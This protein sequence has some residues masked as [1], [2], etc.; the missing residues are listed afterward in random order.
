MSEVQNKTIEDI[1][2]LVKQKKRWADTKIIIKAY[3]YAKEKHGTQCRKSGE[4][5]IIHPVQVAYI[6]ADIG[7]DESTICAA[8]LH[9][10]VEDTEVTHEDLVRDFSEEI[11]NM[12]A[13][14][15][16]LGELRYQASTEE[17]QVE[18]YRKMFLAMG[19][20]IR[21]IIIKL[22]DRLHN[23]RTLKYLRRDRQIANAKETME[24]Y[25][26]LA[27]RLGIY[28]L[29][30][31]LEDLAFK[32]LYPEEY[33][34]LVAGIDKKREERL[35]FIEKI[36]GDIRGSLKKQKIEAEVTGRAKHLY[37]IYRKM[38][39]D[40]KTLDQIYDLFAL[41]ILV[42][43]VKDCYTA[44]GVVH[45]MY[46]PMPGRFK[47]YIAVP[48]PNMYQSIHTTLLG[49]KGTPFEVQIRTWEMHRIAEYGIA[50]HWAYKEA[51][52]GKKGKQVVEVTNDKLSWL[53]ETLE[54]QQDMK[55]PQEF[56]NTLK[57]ELFEDEV[58]VFTPKGKILV[59]PREATPIDFAYS[60]HEEIGNHM[61]GCKINS[62]MMP[63]I[64]KLKSGDI[65][66]IM[67]SD[68]QKGPSRDWLKF[69]KTTKAKSKIQS[70]FKKEQRTENIEK[71]K[72][73]IEKE[74]KRIGI[75]HDELF[76]QDYINAALDRYKFK[77][78]EEMYASVG[79]GAISQVKI[80][81]RML[82][83]YRKAHNEENIEQKIEELTSKR[84]HIKPSNTGVVVKGIDNCLVKLSKCCNPVP[85]DNIIGYITKGRGVSVH[86]TDCVNVKDL[87]KE[88]DRIIDV[89]WYTE[90][91][92]AY[93]VDI[94]VFA[95]DRA[96]L[97]AEVIQVLGNVKTKL[98]ALNSKTT[99]EHIA[100]IEIT[101]EVE[102]IEELNKVLK[103]LRKI[104]S[105][106]EVARKK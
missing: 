79:F 46:S 5:Y 52:Y 10:V 64:T 103:E 88:E 17:R 81:S 2:S 59:L 72:E 85:G 34:E 1:I 30:W 27:N 51:N 4:P 105:V 100:T 77:N 92:A 83:E 48:K 23:L 66:E 38:K 49:E 21:V 96:G 28:S 36:M 9:D 25:A 43:S 63:I 73:L 67:T 65:I 37:S 75:S 12:V 32:Y 101:I 102:N 35:K 89:Y 18:N 47:D 55:D 76:K 82:E 86:R 58:Y 41:R 97:L 90:E 14:V 19:K 33:R 80:I 45:E 84:K 93:N 44:L 62:K 78:V 40:N 104:D 6:L 11:A 94:T 13:G 31:E 22:A 53:R 69:I 74:I 60:I 42:N 87:L 20:D 91:T 3:N 70:W 61:V 24:L 54:W 29:K 95:N 26:P 39:R 71:G 8:L 68:S 16:K 56:L 7:L 98:I 99:K 50:A 15:T 57:T 106:Y